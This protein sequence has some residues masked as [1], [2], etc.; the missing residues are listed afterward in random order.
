VSTPP[1]PAGYQLI[2]PGQASAPPPLPTG[3]RLIPQPGPGEQINDV[4]NKVIVPSAGEDFGQTMK[5]AAA[6]GKTVTPDQINAEVQSAPQKVGATLAAAPAIGF[7]GA[8]ALA[9][10]GESPW[11]AKA[12]MDHVAQPGTI[13]KMPYGR[14]VEYYLVGKLGMSKDVLAKIA[15]AY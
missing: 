10:A 6:Y 14:A 7:G 3:Y 11:I 1:L 8:A 9:G 15:A 2:Q 12:V 13:L 4:G 5:R